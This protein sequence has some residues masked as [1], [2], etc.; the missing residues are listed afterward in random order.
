MAEPVVQETHRQGTHT[1]AFVTPVVEHWLDREIDSGQAGRTRDPQTGD[2]YHSLCY[3]SR[4]AL[5]GPG[6]RQWPSRSYKRPTDRGH[7]PQP[8]LH[9]SWSTGWTGKWTVAE[10]VVQETHRQGTH[11]PVFVTP[12]VEHRLDREIDSGRAGRTRDPQTG[13]TYTSRG[14][15]AGPGNRQW[16]SRSYKR[17]TDR[18]H[19]P[20]PL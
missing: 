12:V 11:T 13:D 7:I 18:G 14:A 19:I 2:T 10:P 5:A 6:N 15:L 20:Q 8:L 3:T 9:Q 17:P 16:T 4:G 1:T